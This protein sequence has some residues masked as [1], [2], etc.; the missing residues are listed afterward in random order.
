MREKRE[1]GE[2]ALPG[3]AAKPAAPDHARHRE[4]LRARF[5]MGGA[6]AVA[7]YELLELLL[8]RAI[9]RRDVKPLAK[10]LIAEFGDFNH[11]ISAPLSAS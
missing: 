10:R 8:F 9:P 4:R 2:A 3:L 1:F 11:A 6:G 7:D 5:D